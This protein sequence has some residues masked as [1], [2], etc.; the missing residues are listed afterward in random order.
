MDWF[1]K[2]QTEEVA[3]MSDLLTTAR[4]GKD[5]P[6]QLEQVLAP[7][8]AASPADDPTAPPIAGGGG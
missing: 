5:A 4:R 2:E 3:K 8:A 6:L 7:L 1:L